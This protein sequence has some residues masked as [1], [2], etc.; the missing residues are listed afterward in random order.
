MEAEEVSRACYTLVSKPCL[1]TTFGWRV[2]RPVSRYRG[3]ASASCV[4]EPIPS[5]R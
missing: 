5:L 1:P 4:R 3:S 2:V